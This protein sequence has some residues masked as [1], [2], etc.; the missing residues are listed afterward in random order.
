MSE[1]NRMKYLRIA[2]FLV[3]CTFVVGIYTFVVVWPSGWSWHTS[4]SHGLPH[5]LEMILGVYAT[6]GIFLLVA[7]RNPLAHLSLIRFTVWSSVVHAAIM[8]GQA[9]ANYDQ[10]GHLLGDVPALLLIAAILGFLT[11]RSAAAR[12]A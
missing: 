1:V 5:Y 2:L 12:P 8:A 6:L 7:S 11:P 9:M 10:R 4:G 3:G